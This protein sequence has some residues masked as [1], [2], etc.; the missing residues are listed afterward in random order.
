MNPEYISYETLTATRESAEWAFWAMIAAWVSAGATIFTLFFACRALSTWR[1]Q[2]KTKVKLDFRA[3]LK[4]FKSAL[5][6][7][8]SSLDPVELEVE[9]EQIIAKWLFKDVDFI[10][11]QIESGEQ[12][13]QRFDDLLAAFENCI[14]AWLATEH[15]FDGTDMARVWLIIEDDFEKY[16]NGEG[17]KSPLLQSLNKLTATRFVFESK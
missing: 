4:H 8:P 3:S 12:N 17:S 11:Q 16:I 2:E 13:V 5:L 15:L 14:S 7:M 6:S 1:E 10:T 9:R